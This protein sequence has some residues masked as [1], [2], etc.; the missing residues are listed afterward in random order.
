ERTLEDS[1]FYRES[2]TSIYRAAVAVD[3]RGEAIDLLSLANQLRLDGMLDEVGGTAYLVELTS[4]VVTTANVE[5]HAR[6]VIEKFIARE[7]IRTCEEIKLRAFAQDVD[8]F[9]LLD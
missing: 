4:K 9:E 7:M 8:T 1:P 3:K 5:A 2:H 6:I